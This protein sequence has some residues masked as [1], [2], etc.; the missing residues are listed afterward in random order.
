VLLV[1]LACVPRA[2]PGDRASA[3]AQA[4]VPGPDEPLHLRQ[5]L[6]RVQHSAPLAEIHPGGWS[7]VVL[8]GL[9]SEL[10]AR[11]HEATG[12]G[13]LPVRFDQV[14]PL[15]AEQRG[16]ADQ[17]TYLEHDEV[18][19]YDAE[20]S[21]TFSRP[22]PSAPLR[23]RARLTTSAAFAH[24]RDTVVLVH[25][26]ARLG[27]CERSVIIATGNVHVGRAEAC[28]VLAGGF[29]RLGIVG[30]MASGRANDVIALSRTRVRVDRVYEKGA[31]FGAHDGV[32]DGGYSGNFWLNSPAP[33][34]STRARATER[35]VLHETKR[36]AS[37]EK[38]MGAV[39]R[40][41]AHDKLLLV[42]GRRLGGFFE[43]DTLAPATS[44]SPFAGWDVRFA[45]S[46]LVV[47]AR[48]DERVW[49]T[50]EPDNQQ[51]GERRT[52][53]VTA[54]SGSRVHV[55]SARMPRLP[56]REIEVRVDDDSAP[57]VLLLMA[58]EG[59]DWRVHLAR[60]TRLVAVVLAGTDANR[61][62]GLADDVPVLTRV[63]A[64]GD[65]PL[66]AG[67]DDPSKD[68]WKRV[69]AF[70]DEA[71]LGEVASFQSESLP[72]ALRV[73]PS[74][75]PAKWKTELERRLAM[76]KKP[77]P[78]H[79]LERRRW[80]EYGRRGWFQYAMASEKRSFSGTGLIDLFK[81]AERAAKREASRARDDDDREHAPAEIRDLYYEEDPD[82]VHALARAFVPYERAP[83]APA[84]LPANPVAAATRAL[85]GVGLDRRC[86]QA[87]TV[88]GLD[89]VG[90][91]T[92]PAGAHV[93]GGGAWNPLTWCADERGDPV[94]PASTYWGSRDLRAR[95]PW[96][97]D[98]PPLIDRRLKCPAGAKLGGGPP[99]DKDEVF[100]LDD[101]GRRHGPYL[102]WSGNAEVEAGHY[103]NGRRVGLWFFRTGPLDWID[104]ELCDGRPDGV[105]RDWHG[106]S[107]TREIATSGGVAHGLYKR[108]S[109]DGRQIE[110]GEHRRGRPWGWWYY[111]FA[112]D[113]GGVE[114]TAALYGPRGELQKDG[115][116]VA[117][118]E[119]GRQCLRG[120]EVR[121]ENCGKRQR[122][123]RCKPGI[124]CQMMQPCGSL[125]ECARSCPPGR[126]PFD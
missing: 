90:G 99:P 67:R 10:V 112:R 101:D 1:G 55:V 52:A 86:S 73:P 41:K 68:D 5:I 66:W 50:P 106:G 94:G 126:V 120:C 23:A 21:A 98:G 124:P 11:V 65:S 78:P 109:E 77:H 122:E 62:H 12:L 39:S 119:A 64:F 57:I 15:T 53:R 104:V 69:L 30:A 108:F 70:L 28:V 18:R 95:A 17:R 113:D 96:Q 8:S 42:N 60:G 20:E 88:V 97:V 72:S 16:R 84:G 9:V 46:W 54:P 27:R 85:D 63:R 118:T 40:D 43:G 22:R 4:P 61:V 6:E 34:N 111:R 26:D 47:L 33:P 74:G 51:W 83:G 37:L 107:L 89:R 115:P 7:D 3:L 13:R 49:L 59:A 48:G 32:H 79:W 2:A 87:Q 105:V 81:Y 110:Q 103:R 102:R 25:G 24:A 36:D 125:E 58:Y 93:E 56:G 80:R 123:I 38:I 100:C 71:A 114:S 82:R 44:D 45:T 29:V 91:E 31:V 35:V 116:H 117:D 75:P 19:V 14:V 92:C 76:A 121:T